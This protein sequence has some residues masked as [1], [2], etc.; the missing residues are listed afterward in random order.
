MAL[1]LNTPYTSR[2]LKIND[3]G[4]VFTGG[5][6]QKH[7]YLIEFENGDKGEFCPPALQEMPF[8]EKDTVTYRFFVI[9]ARG[10]EI[11]VLKVNETSM[12]GATTKHG[13]NPS[14][15]GHPAVIAL[16]LGKDY[17]VANGSS[18]QEVQG[19]ADSFLQWLLDR[20]DLESYNFGRKGE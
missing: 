17:G 11:E 16:T 5:G 19:Y 20:R 1:I 14:M 7:K 2:V 4:K 15:I 6:I 10:N 12:V 13:P 9:S 8:H 18:V 3:T